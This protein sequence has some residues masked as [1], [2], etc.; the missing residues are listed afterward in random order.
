MAEN[1]EKSQ[2]KSN[3]MVDILEENKDFLTRL[4]EGGVQLEDLHYIPLFREFEKLRKDGFKVTYIVYHLCSEYG[5][6]ER[7]VWNIIKHLKRPI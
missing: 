7:T 3:L 2:P 6:C 4:L 5:L 1:A